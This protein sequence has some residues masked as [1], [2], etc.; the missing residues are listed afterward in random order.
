[1]GSAC[2]TSWSA[3]R[4][5]SRRRRS[6]PAF[7]LAAPRQPP[8]LV[9]RRP[10]VVL[11]CAG[12][13]GCPPAPA[14]RLGW[15]APAA[16]AGR[17][18]LATQLAGEPEPDMPARDGD[19]VA[20]TALAKARKLL[21]RV[22]AIRA[23]LPQRLQRAAQIPLCA[24]R[25]RRLPVRRPVGKGF[26]RRHRRP[27]AC[28]LTNWPSTRLACGRGPR[29]MTETRA[30]LG[31]Q[32]ARWRRPMRSWRCTPLARQPTASLSSTLTRRR[33]GRDR[34]W[35]GPVGRARMD[36]VL[37][38]RLGKV[39]QRGAVPASRRLRCRSRWKRPGGAEA[40]PRRP[41]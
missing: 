16:M 28:L 11:R 23:D 8:P 30:S 27:K 5:L 3:A 36:L 13:L 6:Y 22:A 4:L 32:K 37:K 39:V 15:V 20:R 41:A 21:P 25:L 19:D 9:R 12:R 38:A 35:A 26:R 31:P 34:R 18:P 40:R 10:H 7:A 33:C 17:S 14:C 1:M 24:T 2:A 29:R